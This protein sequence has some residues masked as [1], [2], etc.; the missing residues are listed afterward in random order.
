M[1]AMSGGKQQR[2]EG[3]NF[4]LWTKEDH[5]INIIDKTIIFNVRVK[6]DNNSDIQGYNHMVIRN[7]II[8][9][10]KWY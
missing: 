3:D 5:T 4:I 7:F 1:L 9:G 10:K 2:I 6:Q 8:E